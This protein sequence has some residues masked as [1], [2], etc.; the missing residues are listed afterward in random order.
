MLR[1]L[2]ALLFAI[3]LVPIAAENEQYALIIASPTGRVSQRARDLLA[4]Q[5]PG[6]DIRSLT[7]NA[8]YRE[9]PG[10]VEAACSEGRYYLQDAT[11]AV[12]G[13]G[14]WYDLHP[15]AALQQIRARLAAN[16]RFYAAEAKRADFWLDQALAAAAAA[17]WPQTAAI[18]SGKEMRNLTAEEARVARRLRRVARRQDDL[19][20]E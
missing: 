15:T 4:R 19:R 16:R 17:K 9:F 2:P 12:I 5:L 14:C 1:A 18:L 7:D 10:F 20:A 3:F 11:Q 6:V 8:R 13:F